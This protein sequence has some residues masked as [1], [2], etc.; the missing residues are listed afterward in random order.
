[1]I[2]KN[3]VSGMGSIRT[4]AALMLLLIPWGLGTAAA[5]DRLVTE[6]DSGA[7]V[8]LAPGDN[9][10]VVLAGNPTTGYNW[11]VESVDRAVLL[12]AGEPFF[13]RDSGLIGAGGEVTFSFQAA[14]PGRT[15]LKLIYHR[16]FEK[17]V[18]PLKTHEMTVVV[19]PS[20]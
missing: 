10:N 11:Y 2:R 3:A 13:R 16:I 7:V 20:P 1:M 6:K 15:T 17:N 12:E 18:P 14:A 4:L 8:E 5:A 9:L 19:K